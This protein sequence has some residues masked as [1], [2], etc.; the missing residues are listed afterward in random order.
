MTIWDLWLLETYRDIFFRVTTTLIDLVPLTKWKMLWDKPSMNLIQLSPIQQQPQIWPLWWAVIM[1]SIV[2][3]LGPWAQRLRWE[4]VL[5]VI[6][7]IV[8]ILSELSLN[9][10]ISWMCYKRQRWLW[11]LDQIFYPHLIQL[12]A[13]RESLW[14]DLKQINLSKFYRVKL[15]GFLRENH[16]LTR[17]WWVQLHLT[18][19]NHPFQPLTL[20]QDYPLVRFLSSD[21]AVVKEVLTLRKWSLQRSLKNPLPK[22]RSLYQKKTNSNTQKWW[23]RVELLGSS[24]RTKISRSSFKYSNNWN[25]QTTNAVKKNPKPSRHLRSQLSNLRT[26]LMMMMPMKTTLK[27]RWKKILWVLRSMSSKL[28]I[29]RSW[30]RYRRE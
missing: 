3:C 22:R 2:R 28:I 14:K 12:E 30:R 1:E 19:I 6:A 27:N 17:K 4:V 26:S 25:K 15:A 16:L 9:L 20:L 13:L 10:Q 18:K 8:V 23:R 29:S 7:K 5:A 21:Q 24:Q 11:N